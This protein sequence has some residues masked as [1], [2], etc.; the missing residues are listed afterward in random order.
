MPGHAK[1]VWE[2]RGSSRKGLHLWLVR[3]QWLAECCVVCQPKAPVSA[4]MP[5]EWFRKQS[6]LVVGRLAQAS[7]GTREVADMV[8]VFTTALICRDSSCSEAVP[9]KVI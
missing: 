9:E 7:Q 4:E 3:G 6:L 8:G 2:V 5:S 1:L